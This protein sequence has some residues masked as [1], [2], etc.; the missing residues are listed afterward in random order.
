MML[1]SPDETPYDLRFRLLNIPVRVHP[2]FWLIMLLLGSG[3]GRLD[4]TAA[5]VF[6]ACAFVSVLVH[7]MGHGLASR[8]VGNE[9]VGIVLYAMGGYC[10]FEPRRQSPGERLFVLLMGPGAGFALLALVL[11][12]LNARYAVQPLDALDLIGVGNLLSY[13]GVR[14]GN[15]G[16]AVVQI[17]L[18]HGSAWWFQAIYSL[19]YINFWWGVFNL[20]PIWPL[21]GGQ[22]AGVVLGEANPREGARW[23]HILSMLTAAGLAYYQF[24]HENPRSA[25]WVACFGFLNFQ[26]LQALQESS[27]FSDDSDWWRR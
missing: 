16:T 24:T 15:A 22:A 14:A 4:L 2:L 23:C 25:I 11:A 21:D 27:R 19:L 3:S 9:P 20:F 1:G 10:Q 8:A 17:G 18:F 12:Y 26:R 13:L 7:E 6:I 5:A